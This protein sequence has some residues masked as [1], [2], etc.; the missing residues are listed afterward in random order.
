[1]SNDVESVQDKIRSQQ[2]QQMFRLSVSPTDH[3]LILT[4]A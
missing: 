3:S 1:M 4:T 2:Q